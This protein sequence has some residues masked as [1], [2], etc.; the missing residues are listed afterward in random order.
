MNYPKKTAFNLLFQSRHCSY[1][2]Y[3]V[4]TWFLKILSVHEEYSHA[5]DKVTYLYIHCSYI[6]L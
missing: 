4:K 2:I 3:S 1:I 6:K 5:K